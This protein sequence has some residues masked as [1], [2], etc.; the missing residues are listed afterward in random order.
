MRRRPFLAGVS[1]SAVVGLAGCATFDNDDPDD[2]ATVPE[3]ED[4]ADE[5]ES[6]GPLRIAT[7]SSMVTGEE[8][9]GRWLTDAFESAY[10]DAELEW[11]VPNSG[12][13]HYRQRASFGA[14]I[15]ADVY[16]GLSATD[17]ALVDDVEIAR[18]ADDDADDADPNDE[19]LPADGS[20][21][22][23]LDHTRLERRDDLREDLEI[24][25]G[26]G[27]SDVVPVGYGYV[28]PVV[29]DR[30]L[31]LLETESLAD[32][33]G[34]V[35][36]DGLLVQHPRY[37][38]PGRA[39]LCWTVAA[40]GDD[41]LEFWRTLSDGDLEIRDQ[42]TDSYEA[43]LAG[44]SPMVVSYST[45]RV[46]AVDDGR[47]LAGHRVLTPADRGYLTV[48]GAAIVAGTEQPDLA[49]AFLNFLHTDEVQTEL[50]V[51][52]RQFPAIEPEVLDRPAL[53]RE[54]A[55]EPETPVTIP[56]EELTTNLE[57]WIDEWEREIPT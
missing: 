10:P 24:P 47:D 19:E 39:F 8:S 34:A 12:I 33:P 51:R 57:S 54:Y 18:E 14:G 35:A 30:E 28:T 29:D 1:G 48:E 23:P 52:N 50:A 32:L 3:V 22:E 36:D 4:D 38:T 53:V 45:D 6:D 2:D 49:Y 17:L 55:V 44:D 20:L 40:A 37:S 27:I 13:D 31:D 15:D 25:F 21:F 56:Y 16:L 7:Y 9:F 41:F 46:G 26:G 43:Y 5:V 11:T 42:W